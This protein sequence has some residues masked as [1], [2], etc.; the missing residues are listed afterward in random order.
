METHMFTLTVVE[1]TEPALVHQ[2][3]QVARTQKRQ[4]EDLIATAVRDYLETLEEEA[5]HK[6]TGIFWRQHETLLAQCSGQHVA[7]R[8]G[9]VVDFDSGV[10]RL[11][12]RIRVRFG[13]LPVLIAPAMPAPRRSIQWRGGRID[14]DGCACC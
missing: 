7:M 2:V 8:Q 5:I 3:T 14:T 4:P 12:A 6:E 1:L 9:N 13:L 11:E 10:S